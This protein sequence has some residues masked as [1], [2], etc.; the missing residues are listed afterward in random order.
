[1]EKEIIEMVSIEDDYEFKINLPEDIKAFWTE[2]PSEFKD[3]D[4]FVNY[5]NYD[6]GFIGIYFDV[7]AG[8]DVAT[9]KN[10]LEFSRFN[11][12]NFKF[13]YKFTKYKIHIIDFFKFNKSF[14]SP[15]VFWGNKHQIKDV[16]SGINSA[17]L[18]AQLYY[19][20]S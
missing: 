14:H 12:Q 16:G 1:M 19:L 13:Y 9:F 15:I 8:L 10:L 18:I 2:I 7:W 3:V 11:N 4:E 17:E 5:I 6:G 20:D